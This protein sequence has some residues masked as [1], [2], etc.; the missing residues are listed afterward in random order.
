MVSPQQQLPV[1]PH[2]HTQAH[3]YELALWGWGPAQQPVGEGRELGQDRQ[4]LTSSFSPNE[5]LESRKATV[6]TT[7]APRRC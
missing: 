7:T 1:H 2:G 6:L 5:R 4:Q 3:A